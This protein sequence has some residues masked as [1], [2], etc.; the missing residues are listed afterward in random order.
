LYHHVIFGKY[1]YNKKKPAGN[2]RFH[3]SGGA[4]SS[5]TEQVTSSF[6]LVRALPNP[7]LREA[8]TTLWASLADSV[9]VQHPELTNSNNLS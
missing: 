5:Y 8:A 3:A 2:E 7:R 4:D 9:S 1:R 6:A